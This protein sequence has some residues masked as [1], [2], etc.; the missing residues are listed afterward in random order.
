MAAIFL[1]SE[2]AVTLVHQSDHT[3]I[4]IGPRAPVDLIP[5]VRLRGG[6][7]G[8]AACPRASFL[9]L[10][11]AVQT[12]NSRSSLATGA[13]DALSLLPNSCGLMTDR[14]GRDCS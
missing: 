5:V 14:R 12:T 6:S 2:S 1:R 3:L 7:R 8:T 11:W 4:G 10:L 9:M 13:I